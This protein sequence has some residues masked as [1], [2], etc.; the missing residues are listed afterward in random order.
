LQSWK[1]SYGEH[2][3]FC[4]RMAETIKM[5]VYYLFDTVFIFSPTDFP[6]TK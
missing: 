6:G 2:Q 3:G 5:I 1:G 4:Q